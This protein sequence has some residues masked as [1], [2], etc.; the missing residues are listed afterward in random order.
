M[1][2]DKIP[3]DLISKHLAGEATAQ[4]DEL[5]WKWLDEDSS[6]L[7]A[8]QDFV[9]V[10]SGFDAGVDSSEVEKRLISIV[11]TPGR[12]LSWWAIAASV[13]ILMVASITT[14]YFSNSEEVVISTSSGEVRQEVLPDG[15]IVWMNG[16]T[17]IRYSFGRLTNACKISLNGEAYFMLRGDRHP[18][19]IAYDSVVVSIESGEINVQAY[20]EYKEKL[21]VISNG[22]A[23]FTDLRK[24]RFSLTATTGDEVTSLSNYGLLSTTVNR[25][26]NFNSWITGLYSFDKVPE[27]T[28]F[29]LLAKGRDQ[30]G[31]P[32]ILNERLITGVFE[33]DPS[34]DPL[35]QYLERIERF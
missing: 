26:V 8:F 31:N 18:V 32:E 14:L 9:D 34:E 10:Y 5:L 22:E 12:M 29:L 21:A 2:T 27:S 23:V 25:N 11:K 15:T 35:V 30:Y 33:L 28:I 4:E 13:L 17:T 24:D 1:M 16:L 6:H 19:E 7:Q 3:Y 20:P